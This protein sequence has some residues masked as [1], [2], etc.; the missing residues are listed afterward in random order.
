MIFRM[1]FCAILLAAGA[2]PHRAG[3]ADLDLLGET[4][5][6]SSNTDTGGA[7]MALTRTSTGMT[8]NVTA[9]GKQEDFPKLRLV[10]ADPQDWSA[11]PRLRA[12]LRVSAGGSGVR[13]KQIAFAFYDEQTRRADLPD[14]PMTQQTVSTWIP[15]GQ[16]VDL[17]E[18]L[19]AVRRTAI[20]QLDVYLYELPPDRPHADQWEIA[21]LRLED[22]GRRPIVFDGEVFSGSASKPAA[23]PTVESLQTDDDLHVDLDGAGDVVR[24]RCGD[25]VVGEQKHAQGGT[26]ILVR[27][28]AREDPPISASGTVTRIGGALHQV[29]RIDSLGIGIEANYRSSGSVLDIAGSISD[30]TGRDRA[31]TVY[32][33]LPV[34]EGSWEWWDGPDSRRTDPGPGGELG[35]FE[36]GMGYGL[37]GAHSKYPL[38]A[39][40]CPGK[41]GLTLA[42]RM[43][44]PVVHRIA[45]NP[46]LCVFYIAFDFGLVAETR[47]DGSSL[48]KAPFHILIYRH[49]PDWGFRAALHTYEQLFPDFF[50]LRVRAK[51]QGGWFPWG[52]MKKTPGALDAGLA[53][54][55]GPAGPDA[56]KWD[57]ANGP[58]ALF[59]V[60]PETYQ[61][62]M[63]D[64]DHR[65][66]LD[67]ASRR[68]RNLAAGDSA[69]L[70]KVAVLPYRVA[71]LATD[72][73]MVDR[74]RE[75]A[76]S[77]ARSFSYNADG[78]PDCTIDPFLWMG[79][80]WGAIFACNLSPAIPQGEGERVPAR[81]VIPALDQMEKA[82]A[83]YDGIGLDSFGGYGQFSRADY[84]RENFRY[85]PF[86]LCF[87]AV[88][89]RPVAVAAFAT[90]AWVRQ[91]ASDMHSRGKVLMAN[92]VFC[93]TPGW[94]TFAAPY[95]DVFGAEAP[96]FTDP[97]FIRAIAYRKPCTDLPY[98]KRPEWELPYH[99]LH[100][101]YPGFGN[102]LRAMRRT[103]DLLRR[104]SEAGWEPVTGARV[105]P[106]SLSIER[107][108]SGDRGG[109]YL[110]IH[111]RAHRAISADIRFDPRLLSLTGPSLVAMTLPDIRPLELRG[112]R[113][114]LTLGP[115]ETVT[116]RL[117]PT[118]N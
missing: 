46:H 116:V 80:R 41:C 12:R 32:F 65:P 105:R 73:A 30:L 89:H 67:E 99:E 114:G 6:W 45:Y 90:I 22:V 40:S 97:G 48:S 63:Q 118:G 31:V 3:A 82:G 55:W 75:T 16:W 92:C 21:E 91:L 43:D 1:A 2:A 35:D 58:L 86:P 8:A 62:T 34:T 7:R 84:R 110:V 19:M 17:H 14:H 100:D 96:R 111:N 117:T 113:L 104:L 70:A 109:A 85:A 50:A 20:R 38:G 93:T 24:V 74:I 69:E 94:L 103:S 76:A 15:V 33:A 25:R 71:P 68:A 23:G 29:A 115:L 66:T 78:L 77:A 13:E 54:H 44:E 61:Q 37:G 107:Y 51:D 18:T 98:S 60:E 47:V 39:I 87:S 52:D 57:N 4:F 26:G 49:D 102:D 28:A 101:I 53:F 36:T 10:F 79:K 42:V 5:R 64:F 59:Y 9:E 11:Y 106:D 88:D 112:E 95:L 108:G 83:R 72:G 81:V 56:V 27:D